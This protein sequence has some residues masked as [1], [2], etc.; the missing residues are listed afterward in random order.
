MADQKVFS[1][2]EQ[3]SASGRVSGAFCSDP[4]LFEL[5]VQVCSDF[6]RAGLK[7]GNILHLQWSTR[8]KKAKGKCIRENSAYTIRISTSIAECLPLVRDVLAHEILHTLP[9][10]FRHNA[11]FEKNARLLDALGYRIRRFFSPEEAESLY[12]FQEQPAPIQL[13]CRK[14]GRIFGFQRECRST[15]HPETLRHTR[16][17][18]MLERISPVT[19]C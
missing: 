3:I 13:R 16:C 11:A 19:D 5:F 2:A 14:C 4:L 1:T 18:G 7:P 12:G 17:G 15:L 9:G 10:C 8:M 6:R